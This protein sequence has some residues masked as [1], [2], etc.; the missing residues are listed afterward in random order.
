[1]VTIITDSAADFEPAELEQMQIICVPMKISFGETE[2]RENIDLTKTKFYELL[3]QSEEFPKTSQPAPHD[4]EVIFREKKEAGEE[5]VVITL[6]SALSGTCQSAFMAKNMTEYESCYIVDSLHATGGQRM[7][8]E[9]AVRLRDEGKTAGEIA[10]ALA[11]LRGRVMLYACIDTL[12]YLHKGG[13]ISGAAYTIGSVANIKPIIQI[14]PEGK[15]D[16]LAKTISIR[17]GIQNLCNRLTEKEPDPAYPLY[18]L[19]IHNRKNAELLAEQ[20]KKCGY[21]ASEERMVNIG[22]TI[23]THVGTGA[24]GVVYVTK[25]A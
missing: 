12:E 25:G 13:R 7:L 10:E 5:T 21:D 19:Y 23:G 2:Y 22:A 9:Q 6:S 24:C 14:S 4:F 17:K 20:V 18:I 1:M 3:E 16:I 15:V 11:S 8:V